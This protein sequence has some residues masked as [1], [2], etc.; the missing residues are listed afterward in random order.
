MSERRGVRALAV[1]DEDESRTTLE[2]LSG[3]GFRCT[4]IPPPKP[5]GFKEEIFAR[6]ERDAI[7][8][9]LLD[10]RLDDQSLPEDTPVSYRGGMLAAALK[11]RLLTPIILVTTEE[12]LREHVTDNPRIRNLF[13]H[14]LLKSKIGGRREERQAAANQ[15]IDLAEGFRRI[16][17]AFDDPGSEA[18]ARKAVCGLLGIDGKGIDRLEERLRASVP[19]KTAELA[20]WLLQSLL[21]YP[22]PLLD[23]GEARSRLGLTQDS[24]G[25]ESVQGWAEAARYHGVFGRLHPR[26]WEGQILTRLQEAAGD[27]TFSE[28][29]K[30]VS[31]I[32]AA[33]GERGLTAARCTWCEEELVQRTCHVCRG[34]VDAT[35][36]L[37]ARVDERP[38]WALP[39]VV[40]FR[41]IATGRDEQIAA[42]QFGPGSRSLIDELKESG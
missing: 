1:D 16:R 34:A 9:V 24:F 12:K 4:A 29:S 25:K 26:W 32:A 40:C 5:E 36:H 38:P 31:A 41:C 21:R 17:D 22:G 2:R 30:R 27:A 33:C 35:H 10:F 7:D 23:E 18:K 11:E 28:A 14:T 39:A 37:V 19:T 20:N 42:I 13:D 15:I 3:Y 6:I 8:V